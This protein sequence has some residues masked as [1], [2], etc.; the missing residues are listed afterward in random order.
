MKSEFFAGLE[1]AGADTVMGNYFPA[2]RGLNYS[3]KPDYDSLQ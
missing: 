1:A 2:V 3:E